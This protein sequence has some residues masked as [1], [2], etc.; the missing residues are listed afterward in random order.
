MTTKAPITGL[1]HIT[2][3]VADIDASLAFYVDL[4]G[5]RLR[6]I[7]EGGA[8]VEA[9]WVWLCLEQSGGAQSAAAAAPLQAARVSTHKRDDTHIAFSVAAEDFGA[10]SE[11]LRA[12]CRIWKDNTSEGASTYFLDPDG[13]K[14]EIHVGSL[15]TRL[16]HYRANPQKGVRVFDD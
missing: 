1:N 3:C 9:G 4:L 14:L 10:L 16:A 15:E 8:Y 7:W 12:A 6:A 13:H 5:C 2:L 11:K